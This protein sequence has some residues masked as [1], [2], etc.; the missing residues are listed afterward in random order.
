MM[1]CAIQSEKGMRMKECGVRRIKE[2]ME[3]GL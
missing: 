3:N 2:K 1:K